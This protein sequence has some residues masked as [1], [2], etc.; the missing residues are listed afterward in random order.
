MRHP[1]IWCF[2]ALAI[3]VL[4]CIS[5]VAQDC[6]G[7]SIRGSF[8]QPALGDAWTLKQWRDEFHYMRDARLDQMVIQWTADSKEKTTIY[9]SGVAGYTQSTTWSRGLL[10]PRMPAARKSIWA[11]RSMTTGGRNTLRTS[12]GSRTKPKSPML[13]R[14]TSG[15]AMASTDL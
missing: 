14:V 4:P 10:M 11:C 6:S 5:G 12:P 13:W 2:V 15:S 7:P 1:A 3:L 8:L 9:P